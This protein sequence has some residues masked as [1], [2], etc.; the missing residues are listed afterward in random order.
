MIKRKK[1]GITLRSGHVI[2]IICDKMTWKVGPDG[3]IVSYEIVNSIPNLNYFNPTEIAAITTY[4]E[5][6]GSE[7]CDKDELLMPKS[8]GCLDT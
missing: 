5:D 2:I 4:S 8:Y 7:D 6:Y 3:K 1:V